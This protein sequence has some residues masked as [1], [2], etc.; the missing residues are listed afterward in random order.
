MKPV[1]YLRSQPLPVLA[2]AM[3]YS[4]A[5]D[6]RKPDKPPRPKLRPARPAQLRLEGMR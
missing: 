2:L 1:A 6:R 5:I 3:A 4:R